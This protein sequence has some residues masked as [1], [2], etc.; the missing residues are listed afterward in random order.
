[1]AINNESI[2]QIPIST[3]WGN[4]LMTNKQGKLSVNL[5]DKDIDPS[6]I[7]HSLTDSQN[8]N[9]RI[10][11]PVVRRSY[12]ENGAGCDN[13]LR[14]SDDFVEVSWDTALELAAKALKDTIEQH[15]NTAIF[16]GSYGWASAGRFHHAQSQIHRFL[17]VL[18]GYTGSV[19]SYSSAAAEVMLSHIFGKNSSSLFTE[20]PTPDEIAKHCK[21]LLC[22]GGVALKNTQVSP[23]GIGGHNAHSQFNQLGKCGIKIFNVSPIQDDLVGE[24]DVTWLA[25]RPNS[26]VAIMLALAHSL[27]IMSCVDHDFINKYTIGYN[28]FHDYVMG[29]VDGVVKTAQWAAN[30]SQLS[31]DDIKNLAK[32]LTKG[33]SLI[34]VSLSV[35]RAEHGE[36][37]YWAATTLAAMLGYIGTMGGGIGFGY[38]AMHNFGFNNRLKL[39]FSIAAFPQGKNPIN[40]Y[41]PVSRITE[42][43]ESPGKEIDFNCKKITYP[44]IE[45]IYW[46]GGN[47]YHHHQDL[48]RLEKAWQKP[49]HIIVHESAWTATARRA[50]IVFPITMSIERN[51]FSGSSM[52]ETLS[53]MRVVTPAYGQAKD[54][55]WVFSQ[56]AKRF[57]KY[58]QFT[59][60]KNALQWVES[61]YEQTRGSAKEQDVVLPEFQKFWQG[62][63]LN[64]TES[65][66]KNEHVLE[67]F[68]TDPN[69]SKLQTD[70]GKIEIFSKRIASYHYPDCYG[71]AAWFDKKEWLG[72]ERAKQY[73]YH[74]ISNQPK[75]RL[76]S[77][78]DQAKTSQ[79][80]KI[81]GREPA[82]MNS[83]TAKKIG[84]IDTDI[85]RL[86]NERGS[87]LAGVILSDTIGENVVELATGAWFDSSTDIKNFELHGN[88]NAVTCDVGT[89]K[90]AQGP[91]AHSCLV[92]VEKWHAR[93]SQLKITRPPAIIPL[94]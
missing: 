60:G 41:I 42:M 82:R 13:H 48:Y 88:P 27:I 61:L 8:K 78:L 93:L 79:N 2:E 75:S 12:L 73:P 33:K 89:S 63:Q 69:S 80:S 18:G 66:V 39:P 72:S 14:G 19:N 59:Q 70:S 74:L 3:H 40:S 81:Q 1:M 11:N 24:F 57:N 54:D 37:T 17:N 34:T 51:D 87:C 92:A 6:P 50:D 68:R 15:D 76:H 56:L 58:Q 71:H 46:A 29:K 62:Q 35:Q 55:Y 83:R 77:Q 26:D 31:I 21:T 52:D 5:Y 49:K 28:K 91:T 30:L 84:V 7:R 64:L 45:L 43:L 86:F 20:S 10:A 25:A 16:G 47:P 90:L 94:P 23:G 9:W 4:Y 85:I 32:Q 65:L 44:N 67:A 38:G 22:F 36:Q 53:P